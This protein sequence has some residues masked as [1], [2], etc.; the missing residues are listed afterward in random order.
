MRRVIRVALG[1]ILGLVLLV[2]GLYFVA[3]GPLNGLRAQQQVRIFEMEA[4]KA[5]V[6]D[7]ITYEGKRDP[8]RGPQV[9]IRA[10]A[11]GL[12]RAQVRRIVEL[13]E[14]QRSVEAGLVIPLVTDAVIGNV[15]HSGL[16]R[17]AVRVFDATATLDGTEVNMV[18]HSGDGFIL[19]LGLPACADAEC[20][21]ETAAAVLDAY[22]ALTRAQFEEQ[23]AWP[24]TAAC[25][26]LQFGEKTEQQT[27]SACTDGPD[28]LDPGRLATVLETGEDHHLT[29]RRAR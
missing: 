19:G 1:L 15:R 25:L 9:T 18:N 21:L 24:D 8:K 10:D 14:K 28:D 11:A 12:D 17:T 6:A 4:E 7:H 22:P 3:C 16:G 13:I 23:E 2:W 20:R 5:G 26:E 29:P 27:Y